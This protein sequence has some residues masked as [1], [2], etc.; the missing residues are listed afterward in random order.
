MLLLSEALLA[1]NRLE[2]ARLAL[3]KIPAL[4]NSPELD[5]ERHFLLGRVGLAG[6][7]A[8]VALASLTNAVAVAEAAKQ[9]MRLAQAL[10]LE[11]E[12][13]RKLNQLEKA[14]A[15]YQKI[16]A[17]E[18]IPVDQR[19]LA[20]LKAVELLSAQN[21]LTNAISRIETYLEANPK[22]PSADLL[23]VKA[24]ELWVTEF[25]ARA[26]NGPVDRAATTNMLQ[27][28][29]VHF[30]QVITH[31]TNSPHLG[32]AYLNLGWS[33]WEE[34]QQL[35]SAERIRES[36]DAFEK[37]IERLTRS[38]EQAMARYKLGD[39][40][41]YQGQFAAAATNYAFVVEHY[42]DLPQARSGLFDR[43]YRQLVLTSVELGQLEQAAKYLAELRQQFPN[44]SRTEEA[45]FVYGR[46]LVTAGRPGDARA[47]FED[48][49]KTYG[50]SGLVP[51]VRFAMAR[52]FASEGSWGQ[53]I[54]AHESWLTNYTNHVLLPQVEFDRALAYHLSGQG[55]NALQLFTNFVVQFPKNPLAPVAQNW[56]ADFYAEQE[57]WPVAEQHYQKVFENTNWV[58]SPVAYHSRK[59]AA[60]MAFLRQGYGDARAYLTNLIND[61]KCPPDLRPEA[62][63]ILGDVVMEQPI[64][65]NTNKLFNY[66][67]AA[68]VYDQIIKQ[69]PSN[70][71]A[72]LA[73][74]KKGDCHLQLA[75][76]YPESFKH[77]TNA[78][79]TVLRL[80]QADTPASVINQAEVG[81]GKVYESMAEGKANGERE[82]LLRESLQHY[83][84]VV[85]SADPD[86]AFLKIAGASAG[87][88]AE[89]LGDRAAALEL[90]R[91]LL[92]DLPA[93]RTTWE[94]RIQSLEQTLAAAASAAIPGLWG[95]LQFSLHGAPVS[96]TFHALHLEARVQS[97]RFT[98]RS[99]PLPQ[100]QS[101]QP[102]KDPSNSSVH[103]D[104]VQ[105]NPQAT[106]RE[107]K[108]VF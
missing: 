104:S 20:L 63:F 74:G 64:T 49:L 54:S 66:I 78:Y 43:A 19:R 59:M 1:T 45:L 33:L 27:A 39:A 95:P 107:R 96:S 46:G 87:R 81:L 52:T 84:N 8:E 83:L 32:K 11:A 30:Q 73:W 98:G 37:A 60:Q 9:P 26:K 89:T 42:G 85:Y 31:H 69:F 99:T 36:Q 16:T 5:W 72:I 93:L 22:E 68:N 34:G 103:E 56:V 29:R 91:R 105:F 106:A 55:T 2:E 23:R 67:E 17:A 90:Y 4:T 70:R 101:H 80:K 6:T 10:N 86:P 44:T 58:T 88:V 76:Q 71:L 51:E 57:R 61:P 14:V 15:S 102:K 62:W 35:D 50:Q 28:A 108:T 38:D 18:I 40:L 13:Y 65:G 12:V 24:G 94:S 3:E 48:F 21:Q 47:V 77:A 100:P 41:F 92:K 75:S 97:Q 79:Q 7:N 82:A 53:A 25:Q